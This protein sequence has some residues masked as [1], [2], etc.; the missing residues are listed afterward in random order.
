MQ[1]DELQAMTDA[2]AHGPFGVFL[3]MPTG[4]G[5]TWIATQAIRSVLAS[6]KRAIYV[7]PL[8]ALAEELSA[9][10]QL[11]LAEYPVGVFTGD[12][13]NKRKYP[14]P[15]ADARL[16]VM[17]PERLDACTRAWR[18]H[19]KWIPEVDLIVVDEIHL[20]GDAGRGPRLEGAI[21]RIRRLNPF[22]RI[23]GLSATIG[24]PYQIGDWLEAAT[25]RSTTRPI[26][27]DW[28]VVRYRKATDKLELAF[29]E[30]TRI[31]AE[32][33]SSLIFV[34]S[35]RRAEQVA[36]YLTERGLNANHHH[37]GLT[38]DQRFSVEDSFRN[39]SNQVL[40]ATATL[41]MGLNLPVRQVVLY[42]LQCFD[43][44]E[45]RSLSTNTVWQRVGRAGRR[46]LDTSGEAVL[47]AAAWDSQANSY[48]RGNFES[49]ESGLNT[50]SAM[51]EQV[52][53]EVA[54]GMARTRNQLRQA[55]RLSLASL[56]SRLPDVDSV[57]ELMQAGGMLCEIADEDDVSGRLKLRATRLGRIA[58]RHMISPETVINFRRLCLDND[59]LTIFDLLM[60]LAS[61]GE[62]EPRLPVDFEE[63][64]QLASLINEQPS[65]L[66]G[67]RSATELTSQL[68]LSS[69][70]LLS[71]LKMACL[72]RLW[73]KCDD[74]QKIAHDFDCYPFEIKRLADSMARLCLALQQIAKS[75]E[76]VD[77]GNNDQPLP[78][79]VTIHERL[80]ALEKMLAHGIDE[81]TA[82][83]TFVP[84]LGGV[85][86]KRL[87]ENGVTDIEELAFA[88]VDDL[89][90]VPGVSTTR[91]TQWIR[92]A[93]NLVKQRH[94]YAFRES[95]AQRTTCV[96]KWQSDVDPYR[97]R[98]AI[99]LRAVK[100]TESGYLVT[101][102]LEPHRVIVR[103]P[104]KITCDCLDFAKGNLCKHILRVRI[105]RQD[106]ELLPYVKELESRPE[107]DELDLFELWFSSESPTRKKK[108]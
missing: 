96:F 95:A 92:S 85:M 84:G 24:N 57:V 105:S 34:Q 86:A 98:R 50:P 74:V 42:D 1:Q 32:G 22:A 28:K 64:D 104:I 30:V 78:E 2:V 106:K 76:E 93:E 10:W 12:Y 81:M 3:N 46:G 51:A 40:V 102:G 69:R 89:V 18:S 99:D 91:A 58:V 37:A 100:Q 77:E 103:S 101:G 39:R 20:L 83:L 23:A 25:F 65:H 61:S 7:T 41:E 9:I 16:L 108:V 67:T 5:K 49:I 29:A 35:R 11:S 60:V 53:A 47:L 94:A 68:S 80:Y 44:S 90:E 71:S 8:K 31:V 36:S 43:G 15:F 97:L 59:E 107:S 72:I 48:E 75:G 45:F 4:A 56:Q 88:E 70:G 14:V 6:G 63:L 79:E 54:S 62:C 87:A 27:L 13:G 52:V 55:L 66:L 26:P 17:T 19:W 82:T 33:G 73:T 38:R 21:S